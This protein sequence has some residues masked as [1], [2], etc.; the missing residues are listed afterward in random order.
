LRW[1]VKDMRT[2]IGAQDWL[3]ILKGTTA[4]V[5]CSGALQDGPADDL[6]AAHHHAFAA[7]ASACSSAGVTLIQI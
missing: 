4:V 6:E 3:P 1:V 7:L 2:V 5:N